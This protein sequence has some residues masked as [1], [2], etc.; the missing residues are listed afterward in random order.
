MI[1]SFKNIFMSQTIIVKTNNRS[2]VTATWPGVGQVHIDENGEFKTE[3]LEGFVELQESFPEFYN[4]AEGPAIPAA[5][6][7]ENKVEEKK[8]ATQD[9]GDELTEQEK[10]DQAEALAELQKTEEPQVLTEDQKVEYREVLV[11][12]TKKELEESCSV[13]PSAEWRGRNKEQI[14]DFLMSKLA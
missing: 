12:K 4:K 10:A 5:P 2:N 14:V 6:I 9:L 11:A 7:E 3:N 1:F 13:F 8:E